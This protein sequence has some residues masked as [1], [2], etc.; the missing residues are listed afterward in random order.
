MPPRSEQTRIA[1]FLDRETAKIDALVEKKR[2]LLGLIEEK[3]AALIS[4]AVT[5]GLDP[6][7][8]MKD[9]G[10]EWLGQV[11]A[12]WQE[13]A[14]EVRQPGARVT[15]GIVQAVPSTSRREPYI[16]TGYGSRR[17]L[18]ARSI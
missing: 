17:Y 9:S 13:S 18:R 1:A 3:R 14:A 15:Y 11:P 10:I 5:K 8:P 2:R 12:H 7:A 16:R 6:T 4:R